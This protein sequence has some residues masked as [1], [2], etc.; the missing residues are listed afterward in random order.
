M[1]DRPGTV[2]NVLWHFT[3]G[4]AWDRSLQR[5]CTERKSEDAA[6]QALIGIL[7][8]RV[9]RVSSYQE[10]VH[11]EVSFLR[12][13]I[14][15]NTRLP[16]KKTV[17]IPTARVNCVAD[18]PLMHLGFHAR[19]YGK[20][21]IGFRRDALIKAGFNPVLYTLQNRGLAATLHEVM[22]SLETAASE[23]EDVPRELESFTDEVREQVDSLE[24][25]NGEPF[26]HGIDLDPGFVGMEIGDVESA[27]ESASEELSRAL[28]F[29]KTFRE[30]EFDSVYAEREWRSI[31][32]FKFDI[33]DIVMIVVPR[34][35]AGQN[36]LDKL[37]SYLEQDYPRS[38][39]VCAWEDVVE[40]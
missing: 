27:L 18:I 24:G 34:E 30:R 21:A 9:L 12:R 38:L 19:R 10:F 8:S 11:A 40:Q 29:V 32:P 33:S 17:H 36:F 16:R 14:E 35:V 25:A 39:P 31:S 28:S 22:T 1:V 2:S 6:F 15:S 3:G 5:Q 13:D 26:D 23:L 37:H 4:P 20:F 7:E